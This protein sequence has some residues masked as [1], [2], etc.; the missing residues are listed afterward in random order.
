[1]RDELFVR[2]SQS[3]PQKRA[4]RLDTHSNDIALT[5]R[6]RTRTPGGMT[7]HS[8]RWDFFWLTNIAIV[9]EVRQINA[10]ETL[11]LF[12]IALAIGRAMVVGQRQRV[13]GARPVRDVNM[14][15]GGVLVERRVIDVQEDSALR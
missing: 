10:F 14:T 6:T 3:C 13:R 2:V 12:K 7:S 11:D 15:G 1:M 9:N 8:Q 4:C 5:S